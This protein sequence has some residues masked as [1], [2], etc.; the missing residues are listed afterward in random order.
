MKAR[1]DVSR[2]VPANCRDS[3]SATAKPN[4][5]TRP[6]AKATPHRR[7]SR[8]PKTFSSAMYRMDP[9]MRVSTSGGNQNPPG[10]RPAAEATR[11][12][13]WATVKPVTTGIS[14]R[15][16]RKG[17]TRQRMKRR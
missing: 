1:R 9:A 11:V 14:P 8:A 12:M 4:P 6:K 17:I 3:R 5:C 13:E 10:A 2:W 7:C 16:L 15:T